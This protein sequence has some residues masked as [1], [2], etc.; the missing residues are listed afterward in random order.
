MKL[1]KRSF[2]HYFDTLINIANQKSLPAQFLYNAKLVLNFPTQSYSDFEP[3]EE[4]KQASALIRYNDFDLRSHDGNQLH[5][6][7]F[8]HPCNLFIDF[9]YLSR[10]T[11]SVKEK[12]YSENVNLFSKL[13]LEYADMF[14]K[15]DNFGY[16]YSIRETNGQGFKYNSMAYEIAMEK[17]KHQQYVDQSLISL[18]S[19]W[20]YLYVLPT[21]VKSNMFPFD[22]QDHGEYFKKRNNKEK[23]GLYCPW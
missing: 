12:F 10:Y 4:L 15:K 18:T 14:A 2:I 11:T 19:I 16:F 22:Y 5:R 23:I 21:A 1:N 9:K 3:D 13:R 8:D 20:E 7:L 6:S 17:F